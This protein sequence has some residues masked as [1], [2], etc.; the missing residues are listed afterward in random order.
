MVNRRVSATQRLVNMHIQVTEGQKDFLDNL[1]EPASAFIRK[2]IS[3]QMDGH[4]A[5][6]SR[7]REEKQQHEAAL[8]I[9]N[10]QISELEVETN[11]QQSLNE[12]K[13]QLLKQQTQI[14]LKTL[15]SNGGNFTEVR[16]AIKNIEPGLKS[17]LNGDAGIGNIVEELENRIIEVSQ[18]RGVK[19]HGV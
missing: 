5:E 2:M 8:H 6:L 3:V 16:Q 18:V 4:T 12:T 10:A 14:F 19:L 17:K 15:E 9:I 1:N 13:E 7:L 11:R